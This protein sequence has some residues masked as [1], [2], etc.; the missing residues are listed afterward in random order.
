MQSGDVLKN[1]S[2]KKKEKPQYVAF[3]DFHGEK[4]ASDGLL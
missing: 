3:A 2:L 4:T 1:S